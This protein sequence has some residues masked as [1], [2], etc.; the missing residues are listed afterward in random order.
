MDVKRYATERIVQGL[1]YFLAPVVIIA[2]QRWPRQR[3]NLSILGLVT[4]TVALIAASFATHTIHL[5]FTQGV[6][7]GTGA[8]FLYNPFIFYLDEW[9]VE[10]KGLAY[11]VFWA[12]TGIW[13]SVMPFIMEWA[14]NTFGF[15]ATL[16]G[17]AAVVCVTL[18]LL[19]Y[20]VRPRLPLPAKGVTQG[21]YLGFLR[22]PLFWA[23]EIGNIIEGLGY[24]IP[25]IFLPSKCSTNINKEY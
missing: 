25:Q 2:L 11:G 8:A 23:F 22:S 24:F 12:G 5:V 19:V 10:R 6:L 13:S 17:W 14:L 16:R 1:A 15:R 18:G 4:L 9:F 3:K 21:V 7:Y 20:L